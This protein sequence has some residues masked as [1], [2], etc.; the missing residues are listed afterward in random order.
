ME[1]GFTEFVEFCGWYKCRACGI[2]ERFIP[3]QCPVCGRTVSNY[4][5]SRTDRLRDIM[6][7]RREEEY[8]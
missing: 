8:D 5:Q 2:N 7:E 6:A 4:Q 1:E 3:S